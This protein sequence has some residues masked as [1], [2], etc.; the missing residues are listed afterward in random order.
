MLIQN[1]HLNINTIILIKNPVK[2][3]QRGKNLNYENNGIKIVVIFENANLFFK[4][5]YNL[6]FKPVK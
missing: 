2:S 3:L 1:N 4:N 5:A 6:I